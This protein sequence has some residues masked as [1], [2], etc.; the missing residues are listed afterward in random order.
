MVEAKKIAFEGPHPATWAIPASS[1]RKSQRPHQPRSTRTRGRAGHRRLPPGPVTSSYARPA[2]RRHYLPMCGGRRGRQRHLAHRKASFPIFGLRGVR[3]PGDTGPGH[4]TTA[5][6]APGSIPASANAL[7]PGKR[8][9]PYP[10]LLHGVSTNGEFPGGGGARRGRD[11]QPQT[12]VAGPAQ[13][14]GSQDG[15]PQCALEGAPL[16]PRGPALRLTWAIPRCCGWR[17]G[18]PDEVVEG[19]AAQGAIR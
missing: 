10:Q 9:R 7:Q 11:D 19:L 3:G 1:T 14:A 12:N 5:C 2:R 8:P 13:P 6:A 4:E 15:T 17:Q 16:E 18:F